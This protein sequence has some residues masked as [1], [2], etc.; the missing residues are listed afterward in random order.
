MSPFARGAG[1][2]FPLFFRFEPETGQEREL[3]TQPGSKETP[4]MGTGLGLEDIFAKGTDFQNRL[5]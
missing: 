5:F 2:I 3:E 4:D 1:L